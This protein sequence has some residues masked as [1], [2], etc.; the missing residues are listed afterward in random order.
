MSKPHAATCIPSAADWREAPGRQLLPERPTV[1]LLPLRALSADRDP[2]ALAWE[3]GM[4]FIHFQE[5]LSSLPVSE[6]AEK[7]RSTFD[8]F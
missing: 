4:E 3:P 5:N 6:E 1:R 7:A 2:T 8:L